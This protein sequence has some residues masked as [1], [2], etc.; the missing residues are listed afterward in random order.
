MKLQLESLESPSELMSELGNSRFRNL[1]ETEVMSPMTNLALN[2][3]DAKLGNT[4]IQDSKRRLSMDS[5]SSGS[6]EKPSPRSPIR[7]V[8]SSDAPLS[9]PLSTITNRP[10]RPLQLGDTRRLPLLKMD[11]EEIDPNNKENFAFSPP[12]IYSGSPRKNGRSPFKL[13]NKS[14]SKHSSPSKLSYR[15]SP[16][17]PSPSKLSKNPPKPKSLSP[18]KSLEIKQISPPKRSNSVK[19]PSFEVLDESDKNDENSVPDSICQSAFTFMARKRSKPDLGSIKEICD[20]AKD[21]GIEGFAPLQDSPKQEADEKDAKEKVKTDGF[22]VELDWMS[23]ISEKS[24]ENESPVMKFGFTSLLSNKIV[25][26]SDLEN[27]PAFSQ[28]DQEENSGFGSLFSGEM[29]L[30]SLAELSEE[31]KEKEAKEETRRPSFGNLG[32]PLPPK[33]PQFRR[34][35]SMLDEPN[36]T[37]PFK[38]SNNSIVDFESPVSRHTE[39]KLISANGTGFK[40]PNPPKEGVAP[41]M[42]KRQK[43]NPSSLLGERSISLQESKSS[44]KPKFMR[45]HSVNDLG[46]MKY[47]QQ[48][49]EMENILPDGSRM[50][51][52]PTMSAGSKHPNLRSLTSDTLADVLNGKHDDIINSCRIIDARYAFEY[53][54]GHIKGAENWQHG[55]DDTFLKAFLPEQPLASTPTLNLAD[56]GRKRDILVF[57]CEFSSQRGPDFY[58]KL[59]ESDRNLNMAVYPALVYPECYLLHLGYKE[60]YKHYPEL[61]TGRYTEMVDPRHK[62]DLTKMRAKSKSWSG[63]TVA[64]TGRMGR[65]HL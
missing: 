58:N 41:Q 1:S 62:D 35:L 51:G 59:R 49:E 16:A 6:S 53:E 11:Q 39:L 30:A 25:L 31:K 61:C 47:C 45:S 26:P 34:A 44:S 24:D 10:K 65:L 20:D 46:I 63:G 14:P 5:S 38:G 4:P 21:E 17:K 55:E 7:N 29:N 8:E 40:R 28:P 32:R 48:K 27:K 42:N 15:P 54:G 13:F 18:L 19:R 37:T 64:R 23:P 52:L 56:E 9:T 2:L 43:F 57:H 3:S 36:T 50:Y 12:P 33:R 60:F 22:D